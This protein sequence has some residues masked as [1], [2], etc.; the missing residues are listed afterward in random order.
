MTY[1]NPMNHGFKRLKS[2]IFINSFQHLQGLPLLP[3]RLLTTFMFLTTKSIV[4]ETC[5]P[6]FGCNDHFPV[7]LTWLKK[8]VKI[9]KSGHK[10]ITYRCFSK[11][12]DSFPLDLSNSTILGVYNFSEPDATLQHGMRPSSVSTTSMLPLKLYE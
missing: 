5:V 11:F 6:V 1:S 3:K 8:R 12:D 10:T 7:C 9:L 2:I 4:V